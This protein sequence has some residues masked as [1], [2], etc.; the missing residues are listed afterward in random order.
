MT[1]TG[2]TIPELDDATLASL[3]EYSKPYLLY[4]ALI[5]QSGTTAPIPTEL[6]NNIGNIE[7]SR[8]SGGTY[9]V[10]ST[11]SGFTEDLTIVNRPALFLI[12]N[13]DIVSVYSTLVSTSEIIVVSAEGIPQDGLLNNF[14]Y[15]IRVYTTIPDPTPS[16]TPTPTPSV[17]PS[18]T[19]SITITPT[20]SIS[21]P[22]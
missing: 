21:P 11:T 8:I 9:L 1:I 7:W 10:T 14:G 3:R 22:P 18:V 2:K 15:E 16:T 13:I 20:P 4:T 5:T 19:P 12:N 6:E 17:T